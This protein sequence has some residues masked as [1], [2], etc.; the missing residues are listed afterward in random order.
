[1]IGT[2][3]VTRAR[4]RILIDIDP[5]NPGSDTNLRIKDAEALE[6]LNDAISEI[7]R[8]R[9]DSLAEEQTSATIPPELTSIAETVPLG[10]RFRPSLTDYLVYRFFAKDEQDAQNFK[11][12]QSHEARFYGGLKT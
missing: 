11:R 4:T 12:A 7:I 5:A 9:P 2:D 10:I 8:I 1:M 6:W 3:V